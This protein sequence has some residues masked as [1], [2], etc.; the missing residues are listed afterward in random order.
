M[1]NKTVYHDMGYL[2]AESLGLISEVRMT[3]GRLRTTGGA[4]LTPAEAMR[5]R[6]ETEE[7]DAALRAKNKKNMGKGIVSS[8]VSQSN[9]SGT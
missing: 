2:M 7:Q 5:A 8:R 1:K 4:P 9:K 3:A 6:R